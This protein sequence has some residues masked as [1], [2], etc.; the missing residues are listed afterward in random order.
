[1]GHFIDRAVEVPAGPK[2]VIR[3]DGVASVVTS[4]SNAISMSSQVPCSGARTNIHSVQK[5]GDT[6]VIRVDVSIRIALK[7][8]SSVISDTDF[9]GN[10][11]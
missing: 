7:N 1:M 9:D 6:P 3:K 8:K 2:A 10:R 4:D 5:A 11:N